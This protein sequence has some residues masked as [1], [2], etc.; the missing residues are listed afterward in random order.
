VR[1]PRFLPTVHSVRGLC[2]VRTVRSGH[3]RR[4][5]GSPPSAPIRPIRSRPSWSRLATRSLGFALALVWAAPPEG[6]LAIQEPPAQPT[7]GTVS[8][9]VL[10]AD[11]GLPVADA[12]VILE[13]AGRGGRTGSDGGF[14]LDGVAPGAYIL[15]VRRL[16]Y[17]DGALPVRVGSGERV[18]QTVILAPDPL[19]LEGIT[20]TGEARGGLQGLVVDEITRRPLPATLLRLEPRAAALTDSLGV[21]S[22]R[23]LPP[24]GG[25]L[26]V[27]Q[28]GYEELYVPLPADRSRILEIALRPMPVGVDGLTVEAMRENV[29]AMTRQIG[30]RRN[31]AAV[32]VL[33]Y[34]QE[35]LVG[36]RSRDM[37]NFFVSETPVIFVPCPRRSV[38]EDCVLGRG[39]GSLGM[40]V[41]I[42]EMPAPGG[43]LQLGSYRPEELHLVEVYSRGSLVVAYT[44]A[45]MER[46]A[47]RRTALTPLE[48]LGC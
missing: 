31:A 10:E 11:S 48:Y 40:S 15:R 45:F 29:A 21:F 46:L 41:C 9:T 30:N 25:L 32:P 33:S 19:A 34:D 44:R 35:A 26:L 8:G 27:E 14:T 13:G 1:H 5:G 18:H 43:M 42:D 2:S 20:V 3:P 36:A 12:L 23:E 39:G 7:P 37:R 16:G 17:G 28:F 6:V 24:G 47:R 22:F 4:P 38:S